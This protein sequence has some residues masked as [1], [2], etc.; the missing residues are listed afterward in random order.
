MS[1]LPKYMEALLRYPDADST[2]YFSIFTKYTAADIIK[3]GIDLYEK[4]D[5]LLYIDLIKKLLL[6][7][8]CID[9][10]PAFMDLIKNDSKHLKQFIKFIFEYP[11]LT[12][13]CIKKFIL[14]II[15]NGKHND[16]L[17]AAIV[18]IPEDDLNKVK[19]LIKWQN[20][21]FQISQT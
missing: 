13:L 17:L 4:H 11:F 3:T 2:L 1:Y 8:S 18:D 6:H 15:V 9:I 14:A 16:E 10:L 19:D 12:D 21:F 20:E 5:N 7:P